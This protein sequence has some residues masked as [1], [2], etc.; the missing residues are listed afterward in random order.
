MTTDTKENDDHHDHDIALSL[1]PVDYWGLI[2]DLARWMRPE[3]T[4]NDVRDLVHEFI[5][6]QVKPG[7]NPVRERMLVED[8]HEARVQ[9]RRGREPYS[10]EG[11]DLISKI[12]TKPCASAPKP[13]TRGSRATKREWNMR[14]HRHELLRDAIEYVVRLT[15]RKIDRD[16]LSYGHEHLSYGEVT[17]ALAHVIHDLLRFGPIR[18]GP[19]DWVDVEQFISKLRAMDDGNRSKQ[20]LRYDPRL[21]IHCTPW[22]YTEPPQT[23]RRGK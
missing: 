1:G 5:R 20:W 21:D 10:D 9:T 15:I 18:D 16:M 12:V 4:E 23:K 19:T 2:D 8:I 17:W 14:N 22:F 7:F 13:H 6:T 11:R 3:L